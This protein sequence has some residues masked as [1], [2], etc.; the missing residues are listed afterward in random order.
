MDPKL[1]Q[2][3]KEK[4]GKEV[5]EEPKKKE[6]PKQLS[7][8]ISAINKTLHLSYNNVHPTGKR[9]MIAIEI[10]EKMEN[11]CMKTRTVTCLEAALSMTLSIL[12]TEKDVTLA[13]FNDNQVNIVSFEK[14]KITLLTASV[15]N[16]FLELFL[17]SLDSSFNRAITQ[18]REAKSGYVH[19]PAMFDWATEAKKSI[20][21][22]MAFV[23]TNRSLESAPKELRSKQSP[24]ASLKD[25]RRKMNL[26]QAK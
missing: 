21:V 16:L 17:F 7:A 25:Y 18:L 13:V 3:L 14:S 19:L 12:K 15:K 2:H 10:S 20:D 4:E 9:I 1:K 6:S 23:H 26:P 22:F 11:S 8:I 24:V 5:V